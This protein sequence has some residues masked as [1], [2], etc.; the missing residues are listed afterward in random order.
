MSTYPLHILNENFDFDF[1]EYR[2]KYNWV[3]DMF[4]TEQDDIWHQEGNVGI[5]TNMVLDALISLPEFKALP[6]EEKKILFLGAL[7]H[8]VEKR[9]TT[10]MEDGRLISPGHAMRGEI[11]TRAILYRNFNT[12]FNLR[13]SICKIVRYHGWPLWIFDKKDPIKSIVECSLLS[14]NSHIHLMSKA[15]IIGRHCD[16]KDDMHYRIDIFKEFAKEYD[17]WN[18]H[19]HFDS[20]H[21]KLIFFEKDNSFVDYVPFDDTEFEVII[22]SGLPGSGKDNYI[23]TSLDLPQVSLDELRRKYKIK[24]GDK[25]GTGFIIQTAKEKAKEFLR[26]KESFIWNGTNIT[27]QI[28]TQV[29]DLMRSYGAKVK[30]V[31]VETPYHKLMEQNQNRE[32]P[33]PVLELERFINKLEIPNITEAHKVQYRINSENNTVKI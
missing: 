22:M 12:D 10:R 9:S 29:I 21:A 23:N 8:D 30:I 4:Y 5:H 17:V 25:Y 19:R 27:K 15:D 14:N 2:K 13:E 18:K 33:I 28:R 31:Y 3:E 6:E 24:A 32:Y 1:S 11:S 16:D 26:K 20:N 7:F